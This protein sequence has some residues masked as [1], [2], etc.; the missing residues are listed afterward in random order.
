VFSVIMQRPDV[1]QMTV[2]GKVRSIVRAYDQWE[3]AAGAITAMLDC[4]ATFPANQ[5]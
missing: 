5:R 2:A 1:V 3:P 4:Y